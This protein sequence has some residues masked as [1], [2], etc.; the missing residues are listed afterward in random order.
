MAAIDLSRRKFLRGQLRAQHPAQSTRILPPGAT[1]ESIAA[2]T[3]CGACVQ[4][5]PNHIIALSD[6]LPAIDFSAGECIFCGECARACPEPVFVVPA[7]TRF[8]HVVAVADTCL[9]HEGVDC[10][11]CRD[12]CP[13]QAIRFRPRI[14]GPFYPEIMETACTGCGACI[15]ICPVGAIEV[16]ERGAEVAH[17]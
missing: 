7:A 4:S 10:Q 14:G 11:L 15:G 1:A 8:D 5:C 17:G 2:C 3:A 13:E 16:S 9:T 6:R 12:T